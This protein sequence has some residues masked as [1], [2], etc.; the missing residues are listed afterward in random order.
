MVEFTPLLLVDWERLYAPVLF[1]FIC[2]VIRKDN[3][4]SPYQKNRRQELVRQ[5]KAANLLPMA[6]SMGSGIIFAI[7]R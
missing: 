1:E 3:I 2:P 5:A 4:V 7:S 6:V